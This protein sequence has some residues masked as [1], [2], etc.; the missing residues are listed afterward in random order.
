M[1]IILKSASELQKMRASGLLVHKLLEELRGL[2]KPGVSTL[3]LEKVAAKR[4]GR[5]RS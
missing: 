4:I 5:S 2:V 3:D 1:K